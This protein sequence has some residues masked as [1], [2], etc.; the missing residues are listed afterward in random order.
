MVNLAPLLDAVRPAIDARLVEMFTRMQFILG[1][2]VS[3]FESEFAAAMGGAHCVGVSTGTAAL[4][5]SLRHAAIQGGVLTSALTSPFTA[6]AILNAGCKPVF[7]DVAPETLLIDLDEAASKFARVNA[8]VP[9]HL[10]GQPVDMTRLA[11]IAK[12]SNVTLIQDACQAH[13]ALSNG[14]PLPEFAPYTCY[15]FYPTKNLGCLGDGG[16]IVTSNRRADEHLRCLRDGGR[17]NGGQVAYFEGI[18]A[19]LDE[20]HACYLRAFLPRLASWNADRRWLAS[21]YDR[22][23]ADF[24]PV[25]PIQRAA[26]S[27]CHLYVVRCKSRDALREYL[28]ARGIGSGVHYPVPLHLHPAFADGRRGRGEFPRAEKACKEILSLPLWPYML[29]SAVEQVVKAIREFYAGRAVR[30]TPRPPRKR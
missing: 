9:V 22:A 25:R 18:N 5:L 13:S 4:E 6:T 3:S 16:A 21:L 2:Q 30:P 20:I 14:R 24:E 19:R 28:S 17:K 7:C 10:Y 8:A 29:E 23:L 11:A 27:V 1:G 15:S 26:G 12:K